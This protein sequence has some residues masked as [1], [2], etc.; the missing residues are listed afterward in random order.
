[1]EPQSVKAMMHLRFTTVTEKGQKLEAHDFHW[2]EN[3]AAIWAA[4]KCKS[5][6]R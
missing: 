5:Y 4:E 3:Y 6:L 2:P 1:M